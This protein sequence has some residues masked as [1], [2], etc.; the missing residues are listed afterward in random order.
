MVG[1]N[2]AKNECRGSLPAFLPIL[3]GFRNQMPYVHL[4]IGQIHR[5]LTAMMLMIAVFKSKNLFTVRLNV[6]NK[7]RSIA[8]QRKL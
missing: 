4:L 5:I 3:E 7:S 8:W 2:K 1:Y 6:D